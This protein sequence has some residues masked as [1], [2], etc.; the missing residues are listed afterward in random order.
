MKIKAVC[1]ITGLTSR[2]I[3]VYIE[4]KLIF[5][6]FSENYS[7]RRSFEFSDSD[8][9]TLKNIV[10]LRQNDFSIDEIREML[11][12]TERSV[13]IVQGVKRRVRELAEKYER[14]LKSFSYIDGER[15]YTVPELARELAKK[16]SR[17]DEA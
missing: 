9:E 7:G 11:G 1:E 10:I 13:E 8:V 3:R 14:C 16:H 17:K 15:S 4:E 12:D 5:P 2:A 6:A